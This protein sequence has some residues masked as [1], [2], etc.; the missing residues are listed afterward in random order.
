MR[1]V[2]LPGWGAAAG[3]LALAVAGSGCISVSGVTIVD[4]KTALEEQ[5]SGE[6]RPLSA[7]LSRALASPG[8]VPATRAQIDAAGAGDDTEFRELVRVYGGLQSQ[9]TLV[10]GWLV[11][12]CVGEALDGRL[13]ETPKTCIG[14]YDV[15]VASP[16]VQRVNRDRE[17]MWKVLRE[18]KATDDQVRRA[19]RQ[20]H[21]DA[22]VCG[23]Q[24]QVQGGV[25]DVKRCK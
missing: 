6:L 2:S 3:L 1:S 13:V 10:D 20:R 7:D 12:R 11:R 22:L 9:A 16:V 21:L 24:V 17:Q 18:G 19:W 15:A 14:E 5:A 4:R 25:W 8:P 23:G